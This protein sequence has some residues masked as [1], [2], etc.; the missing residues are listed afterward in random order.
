MYWVGKRVA[1]ISLLCRSAYWALKCGRI[2]DG[3]YIQVVY[4]ERSL[5]RHRKLYLR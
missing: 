2:W 5:L 3:L 1:D 4:K